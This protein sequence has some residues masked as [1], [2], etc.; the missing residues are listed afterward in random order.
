MV[1]ISNNGLIG[2]QQINENELREMA[3]GTSVADRANLDQNR[4]EKT[5]I[6]K[7]EMSFIKSKTF[8][9]STQ[10]MLCEQFQTVNEIKS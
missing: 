6:S 1:T 9:G 8:L 7:Q 5:E 2:N 4:F 10:K 3:K